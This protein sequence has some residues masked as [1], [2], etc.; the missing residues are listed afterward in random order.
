MCGNPVI[1]WGRCLK[2]ENP[3]LT[4][5]SSRVCAFLHRFDVFHVAAISNTERS[6]VVVVPHQAS[7]SN[8][9]NRTTISYHYVA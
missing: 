7:K 6:V 4:A 1:N 2:V 5:L 8:K 9:K 3:R